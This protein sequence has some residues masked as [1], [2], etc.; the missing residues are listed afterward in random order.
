MSRRGLMVLVLASAGCWPEESKTTLV[1]ANP[2]PAPVS[3]AP[4]QAARPNLA[5]ASLEAAARVDTLGRKLIEANKQIGLRPMF[6]T[7]GAPQP[8]IFHTG[9]ATITITE[10]LVQRCPTEALLAAVLSAELGKMV[11]EREAAAGPR[12]RQA[13]REPPP[14]VRVGNDYSGVTGPSD[15]T[16]LAE[17]GQYE[18]ERR[19]PNAPPPP[20]PDSQV[21]A[22]AYLKQAGFA[23]SDLD[24]AAPVLQAAASNSTFEKQFTTVPA[25]NWVRPSP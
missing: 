20:P 21:L 24:A 4:H 9:T 2:F 8:E 10:G 16:H 6:R 11:A 13:E 25:A 12:A 17:L 22:R 15:F 7:I 1:P 23:E 3:G 5:P 14:E 19:R 18:K